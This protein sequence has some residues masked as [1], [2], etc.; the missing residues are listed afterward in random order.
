M[1]LRGET[2]EDQKQ[3]LRE[4]APEILEELEKLAK[5]LASAR[6]LVEVR[7]DKYK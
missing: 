3:L 5:K 1:K 2:K 6:T 7:K 4:A